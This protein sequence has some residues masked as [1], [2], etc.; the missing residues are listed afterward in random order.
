ESHRTWFNKKNADPNAYLYIFEFENTPVGQIRFD[1]SESA[2][3]TYALDE[4]YR[5]MGLGVEIVRKGIKKFRS[6]SGFTGPIIAYVKRENMS[7]KR[8]F[9]KLGFNFVHDD[10]F[11]AEKYILNYERY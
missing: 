4:H 8:V 3:I 6:D 10:K 5:G 9:Q 7:S 2:A 11:D 1:I